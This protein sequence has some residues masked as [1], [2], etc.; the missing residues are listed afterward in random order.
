ME[1]VIELL[2]G[3]IEM[4]RDIIKTCQHYKGEK[5]DLVIMREKDKIAQLRKSI[6]ILK[7]N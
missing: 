7:N 1:Y 3:H 2:E 4:R 6:E 5:A